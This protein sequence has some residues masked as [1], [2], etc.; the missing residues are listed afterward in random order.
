M[1]PEETRSRAGTTDV[2][3]QVDRRRVELNVTGLASLLDLQANFLDTDAQGS[4][5]CASQMRESDPSMELDMLRADA[6][7]AVEAFVRGLTREVDL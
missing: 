5:A 4:N 2:D 1:T 3:V 7:V 6:V